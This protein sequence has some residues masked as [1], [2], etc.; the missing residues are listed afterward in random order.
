MILDVVSYFCNAKKDNRTT[1]NDKPSK[2]FAL[3]L[4]MNW[5]KLYPGEF[6]DLL[7]H[8]FLVNSVFLEI[9]YG[10]CRVYRLEGALL[11]KKKLTSGNLSVII[12]VGFIRTNYL[13]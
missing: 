3:P 5:T 13:K 10:K 4:G 1:P 9:V 12:F 2:E 8:H 11:K 6:G 7:M